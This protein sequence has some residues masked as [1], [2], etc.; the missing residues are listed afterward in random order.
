MKS[1]NQLLDIIKGIMIIFIIITHFNFTYP[2]EYRKYGFFFWIDMAVPVFMIISGYLYAMSFLNKNVNS[3]SY[4]YSSEIVIPKLLRF[5]VPYVF[6]LVVEICCIF[7][8]GNTSI[9]EIIKMV[10]RGGNGPGSYYFPI[11]IQL[12]FIFPIIYFIIKKYDLFGAVLCFIFTAFWEL[13]QYSWEMDGFSYAIIILRY[14]SII[15]FGCYIAI[16]KIKLSKAILIIMF[17]VGVAWQI[18]LNYFDFKPVFMNYSWARVNYI[19][20]LFVMAIMYIVIKKFY[21]SKIKILLFQE[22]GKASFD[23]YL[24][25]KVFYGY[26]CANLVYSSIESR[27]IQLLICI[28]VCVVLGYTF[29]LIENKITNKLIDFAKKNKYFKDFFYQIIN[30]CN[31][32]LEK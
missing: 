15:G 17:V 16:G 13:V 14:I 22:L 4:A 11:M 27:K 19:P 26:G 5:T 21:D 1:R 29:Y 25:Q 30:F 10:L 23:I 9:I 6:V 31:H 12:I 32:K 24:V 3:Y 7:W 8:K 28:L 2:N 20:V 18:K